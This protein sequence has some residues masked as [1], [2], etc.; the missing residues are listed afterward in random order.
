MAVKHKT[1]FAFV[2]SWWF[3]KIGIGW[4]NTKGQSSQYV[5]RNATVLLCHG[6]SQQNSY[7]YGYKL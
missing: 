5:M 4:N 3:S 2:G 7:T 1:W 6:V